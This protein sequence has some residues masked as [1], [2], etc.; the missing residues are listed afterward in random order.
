MA[1]ALFA[2][3]LL[4]GTIADRPAP[5]ESVMLGGYRVLAGDFHM[6]SSMWSN[7]M[8]TPWGLVLQARRAGLDVLAVTGHNE[9]WDAKVARAFA[10]RFGGPTVVVGQEIH[11]V[12]HHVVA[13]GVDRIVDF[14]EPLEAQIEDV[15]EQGGVAIAA[16]PV[17]NF[18]PR[19]SDAA[20]ERL[21]GTELCGPVLYFDRKTAGEL[22]AFAARGTMAPIGSSDFHGWARLGDCRTYLFASD[23]SDT[24]VLDAIREHRTVVYTSQGKVYGDPQLVALAATRPDLR[25]RAVEPPATRLLEW[26]SRVFGIAGFAWWSLARR[27]GPTNTGDRRAH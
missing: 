25:S 27:G 10:R 7:G 24:A 11:S 17:K 5:R 9:V 15:H 16:H 4:A 26:I 23:D 18:N 20:I 12:A 13:V 14:L 19:F 22:E 2:S 8:L 1:L 3:G 6:H 21:D